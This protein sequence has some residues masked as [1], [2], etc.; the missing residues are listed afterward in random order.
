MPEL[1]DVIALL[2]PLQWVKNAVVAAPLVF[3]QRFF[4]VDDLLAAALATAA[5]C[6]GSSATYVLNDVIDRDRDRYHPLKS[7]R[8]VAAGRVGPRAA[9]MLAAGLLIAGLALATVAGA[10]VA[11]VLIA[12]LLLQIAYSTVLKHI[13]V[14]DVCALATGF[15]LRAA[16]GVMAVNAALSPWLFACTFLLALFLALGKRRHELVLLGGEAGGH[17]EVL[18]SYTPRLLD[19]LAM[20]VSIATLGA[21]TLYTLSPAVREK[22]GE[23]RLYLTIPFVVFGVFRYLFLVY[24]RK[25]GGNPTAVLLGDLPLQIGIAAWIGTVFLLLYR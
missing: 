6:L 16:A 12:F 24:R 1:K 8:P 7:D 21:Y 22:L 15:V 19:G 3:S 5:F 20:S 18:G 13:V 25:E 23:D 2:R 17:R 9:A 10:D 11:T 4:S 14:V